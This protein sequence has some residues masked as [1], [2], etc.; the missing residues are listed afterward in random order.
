M[1]VTLCGLLSILAFPVIYITFITIFILKDSKKY[2][3]VNGGLWVVLSV[4]LP[5]VGP[6]LY[7]IYRGDREK[8]NIK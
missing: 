7:L 1:I 2:V 6:I 4:V 8:I 5:I 3:N